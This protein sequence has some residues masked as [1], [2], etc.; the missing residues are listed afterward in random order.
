MA[1]EPQRRFDSEALDDL[2]DRHAADPGT[3]NWLVKALEVLSDRA[4]AF[5]VEREAQET[6]FIYPH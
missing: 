2:I 5:G 1:N 4:E 6:E 3:P